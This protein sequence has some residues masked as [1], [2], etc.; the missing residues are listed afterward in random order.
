MPAL[1]MKYVRETPNYHRLETL[2]P[3]GRM[4]Y[5]YVPKNPTINTTVYVG[6]YDRKV[7]VDPPN[8]CGCPGNVHY[9]TPPTT[10]K[11]RCS[12]HGIAYVKSCYKC[13]SEKIARRSK[14]KTRRK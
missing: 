4:W 14:T 6:S 3:N 10:R 2:L 7:P 12:T 5:V 8:D 13:S 11:R 9:H 1:N